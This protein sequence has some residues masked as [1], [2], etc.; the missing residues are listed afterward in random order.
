MLK[1]DTAPK[2][3]IRE[4]R[5]VNVDEY[6][7]GQE[8]SVDTFE[9]GDIMLQAFQK[10]KVQGAIKR[11]GQG[12]GPM[13]HGSHFHRAPGSVGM[14]S[15]ASK[16]LKDKNARTHGWKHCY[17]SNLE[18]VQIDTENSVILVKGNVPGSK[19]V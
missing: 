7:V 1:A 6:E 5:N 2:R 11:H 17:C 4:F 9:T 12:R 19:K 14:A 16:V 3:F 15:D 13:A 8:V 18:V 10:V